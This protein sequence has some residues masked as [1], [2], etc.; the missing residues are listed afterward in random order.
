[1]SRLPTASPPRR[2][3]SHQ[4]QDTGVVAI[5]RAAD[6]Q[7]LGDVIDVLVACGVTCLEIT[8]NTPGALA[9]ITATRDRFGDRV[10]VGVGTVRSAGQVGPAA[11]AGA[12]FIVCPDT[13]PAVG[14]AVVAAGL[15]WY[16][17]AFTA[18]EATTA[19]G[20]GATA[21]K[22]FPASVGGPRYLRE[23]RAPLDDVPF[24]P[25]GGVRLEQVPEYVAA[26]AVALGIGSPLL[27]NALT[28]GPLDGEDGL[29]AR[30]QE[31]VAAVATARA[32][33][34]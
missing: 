13:V 9:A 7:R 4:L 25:T 19:W 18:S 28:G 21:V 10:D 20:A 30:A 14:A 1:M 23:L 5:L 33:I 27:G 15:S 3:M 6:G 29:S 24:I 11:D 16:P 34:R 32:A 26:G 2:P 17:G 22:L 8:M 31:V 12:R